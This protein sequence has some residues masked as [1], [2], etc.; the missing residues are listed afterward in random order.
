M[1]DAASKERF[2]AG[3]PFECGQKWHSKVFDRIGPSIGQL[4][5]GEFPDAFIGIQFRRI[6]RKQLEV[7]AWVATTHFANGIAFVDRCVIPND[8]HWA[9]K[10]PEKLKQEEACFY[11]ADVGREQLEVQ[12]QTPPLRADRNAGDCRDFVAARLVPEDRSDSSWSPGLA[13]ARDQQKPRFIYKDEVGTHPRGV[14]F[15][16][17]Q[18][19]RFHC[20]TASSL[21]SL[22]RR[23]GF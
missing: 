20:S 17:G 8:N 3:D 16:C 7:Q 22:A 15:T 12:I 23:A 9:A 2:R 11:M 14:F 21:R 10:M 5:F 18:R 1:V 6:G 19:S 13:H 4:F